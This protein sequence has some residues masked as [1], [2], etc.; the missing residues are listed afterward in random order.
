MQ[1]IK[2][3][4]ADLGKSDLCDFFYNGQE[5]VLSITKILEAG[6]TVDLVLTDFMM[7]RVN[8]IQAVQQ[9]QTYVNAMNLNNEGSVKMPTF[10]FLTA[11]KTAAFSRH[12][13]S[14]GVATVLE[15]PAT[16]DQLRSILDDL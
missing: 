11:H 16:L 2:Q 4:L 15:K 12:A 13:E 3:Q 10:V 9:I 8:G 5:L 1:V 14:L 7:P 6:Q